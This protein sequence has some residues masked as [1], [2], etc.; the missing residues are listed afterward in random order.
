MTP[1]IVAFLM[2]FCL[3]AAAS[4]QI[5][6]VDADADGAN[7]GSSWADAYNYLQDALA[8]AWSGDEI[9]VAQGTYKPDQGAGITPGDREATFQLI[10]GVTTK[11]NYAGY[12]EPDPNARDIKLYET[13]LSGDLK[14]DDFQVKDPLGL[15]YEPTRAENSRHVITGGTG[16]LDGF[17]ITAGNATRRSGGGMKNSAGSPTLINCIFRGNS[18]KSLGGGLYNDW[19]S[20]TL[21]NCIFIGNSARS[22]AGMWCGDSGKPTLINCTLSGNSASYYGGGMGNNE[23]DPVL[24]NCIF[25]GNSD[26]TGVELWAQISGGDAPVVNYS[27]IQGLIGNFGGTGNIGDDPLFVEAD[28][29]DNI[30]GTAD[31]NLRLLL[32]SPCIDAADN[33]AIPPSVFTDLD[34]DP[35][36]TDGTVDMGAYE[37]LHQ[38]FLLS[39]ESVTVPEG[40]TESFTIALAMDPQGTLEVTVSR[41]SGDHDITVESG[42]MLTFDSSNYSIPQNVTLAAAEDKDNLSSSALVKVSGIQLLAAGI[43]AIEQDNDLPAGNILFVDADAPGLNT[44]MNFSKAYTQLQDALTVAAMYPGIVTEVRVAEGTYKPDRSVGVTP[45][46]R[47][48][49]FH[50]INGLTIKGGY[51]GFGEPKPNDREIAKYQTILSGDL[52][53]DDIEI[54]Y[55]ENLLYEPTRADNSYHVLTGSETDATAVLDGFTVVAGNADGYREVDYDNGGGMYNYFGSP[56]VMNCIFKCNSANDDG[57]GMYNRTGMGYD[58]RPI[59]TNCTFEGNAGRVGGGAC[60]EYS[61]PILTN[62]TFRD[63]WARDIGGGMSGM[64]SRTTLTDCTFYKN[65]TDGYAGGGMSGIAR[66]I[67]NCIFIENSSNWTGGGMYSTGS[68]TITN[69]IFIGNSAEQSGGGVQTQNGRPMLINCTFSGNSAGKEGGGLFSKYSDPELTNCILWGNWPQQIGEEGYPV[70]VIY[71]DVQGS[72]PGEGNMDADPLFRDPYGADDILGTKDD[73]LRLLPSSPCID[74]GDPDYVAGPD[75]TDLDG[76]PRI[77]G[78]RIDMGAYE[79][80]PPIPAEVRF[81]PRTINLLSKGKWITA[82]LWLPE[83]Y[84]VTDIDPNSVFLEVEIQAEQL[85]INEQEQVAIAK[86]V[87]GEVQSILD[88]SDVELKIT[89]RL[90]DGALFEG[91]DTIKV[92]DKAGKN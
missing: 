27:C 47:T 40:A 29:A 58:S 85:H 77:I 73:N 84:N 79:Y 28:G 25:W 26:N 49:T 8:A 50:L 5:I 42:A 60:N 87:R 38:G 13:I 3:S 61:S 35:R 59:L 45:G 69:C 68:P 66:A 86:F 90:T 15:L 62:C 70:S 11:G 36:I 10:N 75:E 55:P 18:A 89:G 51:A 80:S 9:R 67:T 20:P 43:R 48:A 65:H 23:S 21:I 30:P 33:S 53:G 57:G 24:T 63:N 54:V 88:I 6:Y 2:V 71:C 37:G 14:G 64:D 19:G 83:D 41:Q 17:I 39:T 22:G 16:V 78:G 12:N 52:H 31:D 91:T 74:A 32:G 81:L 1:A 72:W 44:G 34:G 4:G 56:T 46:D 76:K 82:F 92:I 7:N